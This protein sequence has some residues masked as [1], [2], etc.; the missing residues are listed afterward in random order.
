MQNKEYNSGTSLAVLIVSTIL[1]V[2]LLFLV[3]KSDRYLKINDQE[4]LLQVLIFS[5]GI[6]SYLAFSSF[7]EGISEFLG[8]FR[9][10]KDTL[11]LVKD[12]AA[13]TLEGVLDNLTEST[14]VMIGKLDGISNQSS[15]GDQEEGEVHIRPHMKVY[16]KKKR[17]QREEE[18]LKSG[19]E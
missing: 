4:Y 11:I 5:S 17:I 16:L 1:T 14:T 7:R 19:R 18:T 13:L 15:S 6:T 9:K 3:F 12:I 10:S 2:L 8:L